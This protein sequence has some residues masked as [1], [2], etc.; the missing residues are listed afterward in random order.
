MFQHQVLT[1]EDSEQVTEWIT[2]GMENIDYDA[3]NAIGNFIKQDFMEFWI[4]IILSCS[5]IGIPILIL[6]LFGK[7][8]SL[9][10]TVSAMIHASGVGCGMSFSIIVFMLPAMIKMFILLFMMSSSLKFFENLFQYKKEIR[11]EFVR[12]A[13]AVFISFLVI[14]FLTL[15]RAFSLNLVNQILF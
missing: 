7:A 6:L 15:Y 1:E 12:H 14:C 3:S 2:Q 13:F 10:V 11:Y 8:I 5:F 9:G 4:M